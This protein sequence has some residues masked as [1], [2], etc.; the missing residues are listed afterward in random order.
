M[1]IKFFKIIPLT[2]YLILNFIDN[3]YASI[4]RLD[5]II[6]A[7]DLLIGDIIFWKNINTQETACHVAIVTKGGYNP[8]GIKIAHA[9]NHLAYKKFTETHIQSSKKLEQKGYHYFVIRINNVKI[10]EQFLEIIHELLKEEPFFNNKTN[11]LM[12]S[13]NE[14]M[15]AYS[16]EIKLSIQNSLFDSK[17]LLNFTISKEGLMCSEAIILVLQKAFINNGFE[18]RLIPLSLKLDPKICPPSLMMF[19]LTKDYKNF[20]VIGN[21]EVEDYNFNTMKI[22]DYIFLFGKF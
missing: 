6:K 14:S 16:N 4:E 15:A 5:K 12:K 13:W 22:A 10:K 2:I 3:S 1:T 19:A 21:L 11:K 17:K 9:T 18:K 20:T 8:E 7:K